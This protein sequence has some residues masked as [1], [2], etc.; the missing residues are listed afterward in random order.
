MVITS[1]MLEVD[2]SSCLSECTCLNTTVLITYLDKSEIC[3][4]L[5]PE[6]CWEVEILLFF[7]TVHLDSLWHGS[8]RS[9]YYM[10]SVQKILFGHANVCL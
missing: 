2:G 1:I 9:V 3:I 7:N 5:M 4:K 6:K 8:W 10:S